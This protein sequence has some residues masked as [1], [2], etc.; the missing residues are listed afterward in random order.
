M[1]V[2]NHERLR[3][4][5][6]TYLGRRERTVAEMRLRLEREG[7]GEDAIELVLD[8]LGADALLDDARYAR[9]FIEDKRTLEGWGSER[10]EHELRAR[11]ID[12]ELAGVALGADDGEEGELDRA[13]AL[14]RRRFP[15]PPRDR[16]ARDRALGVLVRKGY[17]GEVAV[18]ALAVHAHGE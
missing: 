6:L 7:A 17:D 16:R 10:I 5:A 13:L 9:L 18:D 14:L 15:D 4:V 1:S 2:E 12:R 3:Q 8:E 11:G